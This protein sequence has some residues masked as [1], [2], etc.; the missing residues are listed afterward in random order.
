MST[1]STHKTAKQTK[2]SGN[3]KVAI[4]AAGT[5]RVVR[6]SDPAVKKQVKRTVN[7]IASS[8]EKSIEFLQRVGILTKSGNLSRK[9]GG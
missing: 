2:G 7:E 9:Y 3:A 6:L 4:Q 8:K 1:T 5:G